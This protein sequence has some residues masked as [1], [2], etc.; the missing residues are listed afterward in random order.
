MNGSFDISTIVFAVLAVFV[1]WK[2]R[3]VLGTRTGNE[4][5][6]TDPFTRRKTGMAPGET[7]KVIPLPGSADRTIDAGRPETAAPAWK[8][9]AE[10]GSPVARGLDDIAKA[11]SA[12]AVA[13]FMQGARA[14]YEAIIVAF[15]KGD[16][17]TLSP[18]LAR[19]VFDGFAAEIDRRV[20]QGE[21]VETTFVGIDKATIEDAQ[22]RG[23]VEQVGIR[24]LTKL[25][26]VTR[27]RT[28]AVIDGD[29]E[30]VVDIVD[31]WS[32]SRTIGARDP[33]WQ[34]IATETGQ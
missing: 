24:F 23:R 28:G 31:L 10:P 14:A 21:T 1:V 34:L 33:N 11:D 20:A 22:V 12:F 18:L 17:A 27:D 25:I 8:G 26:T 9:F 3:S 13:P 6:P 19:D 2:L 5:P 7:G 32:F 30:T 16:K 29:A 15:A 4:R